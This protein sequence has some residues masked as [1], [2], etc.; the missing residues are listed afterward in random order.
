MHKRGRRLVTIPTVLQTT[1]LNSIWGSNNSSIPPGGCTLFVEL[2]VLGVKFQPRVP[3]NLASTSSASNSVSS[4][5]PSSS[6]SSSSSSHA[7]AFDQRHSAKNIPPSTSSQNKLSKSSKQAFESDEE[8]EEE[9]VVKKSTQKPKSIIQS[10]P[11]PASTQAKIQPPLPNQT[12][13]KP[14]RSA[15][16]DDDEENEEVD[17]IDEQ[18][19][20]PPRSVRS[21]SLANTNSH[22]S[23]APIK[24]QSIAATPSTSQPVKVSGHYC[25]ESMTL[26]RSRCIAFVHCFS[27][28]KPILDLMIWFHFWRI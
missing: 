14:Q 16:D 18:E 7:S 28:P 19:A 3:A 12:R 24:K 22:S 9:P 17:V 23:N 21:A 27:R 15:W 20:L 25:F 6:S 26:G 8:E 4:P 1:D 5:S 2:Q 11:S 10:Q 13:V